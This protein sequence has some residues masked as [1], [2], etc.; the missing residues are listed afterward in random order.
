MGG[1]VRPAARGFAG[2]TQRIVRFAGQA[3]DGA[4]L[5][6]RVQAALA[7]HKGLEGCVIHVRA[8]E[9]GICLTGTAP[10]PGQQRLAAEVARQTVG[11]AGVHNRL[12]VVRR[13]NASGG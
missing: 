6:A 5:A 10:T 9:G 11:V 1:R 4:V 12:R 2:A 3:A 7:M 8:E 13:A